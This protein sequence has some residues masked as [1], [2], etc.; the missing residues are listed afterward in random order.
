MPTFKSFIIVFALPADEKSSLFLL[1]H[2]CQVGAA[3]ESTLETP[4]HLATTRPHLS[5]K[6]AE[7]LVRKGANVNAQDKRS[8]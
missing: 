1:D 8:L 2:G 4:L 5:V 6:V 3:L 7:T